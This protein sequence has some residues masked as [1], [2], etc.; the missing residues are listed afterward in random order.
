MQIL[1][2]GFQLHCPFGDEEV[3]RSKNE[4]C[5]QPFF[6]F[7]ER[8]VQK[9]ADFRV[10]LLVSGIWIELAEKLDPELITRL[11]K[12][13]QSGR[14]EILA[15]PYY[16]SLSFFYDQSEFEAEIWLFQEKVRD[17]F[18]IECLVLAHPDLMYNDEI[19]H[20]AEA[21]G[22]QAV[23]MGDSNGD[24][25]RKN[26]NCVYH[27]KDCRRLK[28]ICR[29]SE[30]SDLLML[31][32]RGELSDLKVTELNKKLELA[33]LRGSLIN[34]FLD[35]EAFRTQRA[36]G[37]IGTLDR[38]MTLR[39]KEMC[40]PLVS[41]SNL[42]RLP[43][44]GELSQRKTTSWRRDHFGEKARHGAGLVLLSEVENVL[45]WWLNNNYQRDF[46]QRLCVL[47]PEVFR[48]EDDELIANFCRLMMID[49]I[50]ALG[51]DV[52]L[53]AQAIGPFETTAYDAYGVAL[54]KLDDMKNRIQKKWA[55]KKFEIE[56]RERTE[57]VHAAGGGSSVEKV[58]VKVNF[59][60]KPRTKQRVTARIT[61]LDAGDGGA[62]TK[63]PVRIL[64]TPDRQGATVRRVL[65]KL[66][67]E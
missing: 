6:A 27:A 2:L 37:I 29:N 65:R 45:P 21:N 51:G 10:S 52:L 26:E 41:S 18:G 56:R 43:A 66:V 46:L 57:G 25:G 49:Q 55:Q 35:V 19:A 15:T 31:N 50:Y 23:L 32:C 5:Y 64:P 20:W 53:K 44:K 62:S 59:G 4:A 48:T 14:V 34:I 16:Y 13:V 28:V 60:R 61:V 22:F 54:Q 3:F 67:I 33:S 30:I 42:L 39:L 17:L 40:Q 24:L 9:Y 36:A 11:R 38:L 63:I 1:H 58:A 8:N 7:L 47:K 12:L